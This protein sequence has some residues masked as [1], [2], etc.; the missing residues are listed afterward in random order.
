MS[1]RKGSVAAGRSQ[2]QRQ[3]SKGRAGAVNSRRL[4]KQVAAT[5]GVNGDYY[6]EYGSAV[7]TVYR[8]KKN[9][10]GKRRHGPFETSEESTSYGGD[11]GNYNYGG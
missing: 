7:T 1:Q 5:Q 8:R 10:K 11:Y 3:K 6:G 2:R 4:G 9:K